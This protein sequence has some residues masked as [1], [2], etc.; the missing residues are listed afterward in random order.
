MFGFAVS[1]VIVY[2]AASWVI[3]LAFGKALLRT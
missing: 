3:I 1:I 2:V